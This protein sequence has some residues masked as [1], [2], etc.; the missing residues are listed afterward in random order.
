MNNT[1]YK[2]VVALLLCCLIM[3]TYMTYIYYDLF[4]GYQATLTFINES[5]TCFGGV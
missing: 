5:C 3:M 2:L 4:L 1:N